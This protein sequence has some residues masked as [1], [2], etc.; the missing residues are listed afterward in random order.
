[1]SGWGQVPWLA[2]AGSGAL[3][4]LGLCLVVAGTV[5]RPVR[6]GDA[7]DHLDGQVASPRMALPVDSDRGD[8]LGHWVLTRLRL[9]ISPRTARMLTL[10]NRTLSD[11]AAEKAIMAA[12]GFLTPVVFGAV[13]FA[14]RLGIG[15]APFGV[16]VAGA[17]LGWFVPDLR[18]RNQAAATSSDTG[19]AICTFVDLVTLERLANQSSTQALHRAASVSQAPLFRELQLALERTMLEQRPAWQALAQVG[20]D[21]GLQQLVDLAEVMRLD[22][23]GAALSGVLRARSAELRDRQLMHDKVAAQEV[24]ESL[25]IWMVIPAMI[26]GLIF[27][28]PPLIRLVGGS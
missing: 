14:L 11:F 23:Q 15:W 24:S 9:P 27:L 19:E 17:V 22:E 18:L 1:M 25:T 3:L 4:A 21:L 12:L 7:L 26:F 2:I 10:K 16:G 5:R 13:A 28:I 8:R 6:L 20:T